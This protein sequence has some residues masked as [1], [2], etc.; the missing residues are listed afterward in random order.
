MFWVWGFVHVLYVFVPC[1]YRKY[2]LPGLTQMILWPWWKKTYLRR[3]GP[4][5]PLLVSFQ[6]VYSINILCQVLDQAYL[7]FSSIA[8]LVVTIDKRF[9]IIIK[10]GV[11][12]DI[13]P[14]VNGIWTYSGNNLFGGERGSSE[15][16]M[17]S[18][19]I[20]NGSYE[21]S[22]LRD[23]VRKAEKWGYPHMKFKILSNIRCY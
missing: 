10:R 21:I 9:S 6:F 19:I 16:G 3:A 4:T 8:P 7:L 5:L 20:V 13:T 18:M 11:N 14:S 1:S 17:Q 15:H 22:Y 23:W 12:G 2:K